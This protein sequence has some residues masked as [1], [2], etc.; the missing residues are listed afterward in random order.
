MKMPLKTVVYGVAAAVLAGVVFMAWRPESIAVETGPVLVGPM[1]VTVEEQ[2][3]TRSHD[4]FVVAAPVNGRL[5]RVLHHDGDAVG[6][7]DVVATIAPVPLSARER[8]ELNAHVAAAAAAQ[9]SAEAQLNH[10]VEDLA[11]AQRESARMEQLFARGLVARQPLEQAQN[12]AGTLEKEVDAARYRAK[13]AAAELREAQAGLIALRAARGSDGVAEIRAPAAGRILRIL[14]ASERV[15]T[16]GT[17][18]LVIG[19]LEH[20]EV[21]ME[22]LSSEAV[23]LTAG[24]PALLESWGGDKPLRARV[25]LV[26]PYAFTKVSALGVEEKRTNV[27]LD[28]IDPPGTLGDGYRV[29]GRIITWDAAAVLKAPVSALFRCGSE[30]CVFVLDGKRARRREVRLGH[31]SSTETEILSG[32]QAND[33]VIRH[34]SNELTDGARVSPIA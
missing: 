3:E 8:D 2:G 6:V 19:D 4:R 32:L 31:M 27:V 11:Q 18:I 5:L 26:E 25:R 7:N 29:T 34:P 23:K 9:R 1:Q 12:A 14:E 22:M 20:L 30:W 28:F 24:M 13:A 33:R 21:V 10:V 16:A 17:P 15:V